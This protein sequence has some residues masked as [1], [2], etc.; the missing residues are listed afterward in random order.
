FVCKLLD[1]SGYNDFEAGDDDEYLVELPKSVK[2]DE[3][4]IALRK[5][6]MF[7]FLPSLTDDWHCANIQVTPQYAGYDLCEPVDLGGIHLKGICGAVFMRFSDALAVKG[8]KNPQSLPVTNLK[9]RVKVKD[10]MWSGSDSDIYIVAYKDNTQWA[11]VCLDKAWNNDL[12]RNETEI[13]DIPI[14][15]YNG[16]VMHIPLDQLNLKIKHEGIDGAKW[17]S[18]VVVPYFG[19]LPLI[20]GAI[21]KRDMNFEDCTL[22][23]NAQS[24]LKNATYPEYEPIEIEYETSLDDGLLSYMG[25]LDGGEEWVDKDNELWQNT[26]L[27]RDIFFKLFKGF[28]PEITYVRYNLAPENNT[29]DLG[30]DFT[31]VWNGVSNERRS[32]VKDLEHVYPVEGSADVEVINENGD[33]VHTL[34]G[35]SVQDGSVQFTLKTDGWESGYYDLKVSYSPNHANPLY[36]GTEMTYEKAVLVGV[37]QA[38]ITPK[39]VTADLGQKTTLTVNASGGKA[40][41]TYT[42]MVP[43]PRGGYAPIQ[44]SSAYAGQGTDTLTCTLDTLGGHSVICE[45]KDAVGSSVW[46][47]TAT[48][49]VK[50]PNT[51][52]G[53][54]LVITT[55]PQSTTID[56]GQKATLTVAASGGKA[57]YTYSW[58]TISSLGSWY[59]VQ[60]NRNYAGQGTN[61]FT[62]THDKPGTAKIR[63]IV[64][65]AN[66]DMVTSD[67][68]TITVQETTAPL[69]IKTQ[70]ANTT[71]EV[72]GNSGVY[73]EAVGGKAPYTYTWQTQIGRSWSTFR[74]TPEFFGQG[75]YALVCASTVAGTATVRCVV[76]DSSGQEVTSKSATITVKAAA[77]LAVRVVQSNNVTAEAGETVRFTVEVSG[78]KAP[79]KFS[80]QEAY[81]QTWRVFR[82]S[83]LYEGQGTDTLN[84]T[85]NSVGTR[86]FRCVVTDSAGNSVT[87]ETISVTV[88]PL[89]VQINGGAKNITFYHTETETLTANVTGGVGPYTYAW[90]RKDYNWSTKAYEWEKVSASSSYKADGS[91]REDYPVKV[92]VTDS[93]GTTVTAEIQVR[94]TGIVN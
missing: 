40:P 65:D 90:Y 27:R 19:D 26:A 76:K 51:G 93:T 14:S 68:A 80:W 77:P 4:E 88:K 25:S 43:Q 28:A 75:T 12:E 41:Y 18:I 36:S 57:P 8:N 22:D 78:G 69:T 33:V 61:T 34:G 84:V 49:T 59:S 20:E 30:F 58:Q 70:P 54:E 37:L 62:F 79:Y 47:E 73:V 64:V 87:T 44:D 35:M 52:T 94:L 5:T 46:S 10:E 38:D 2:L 74:D 55:Q 71:F 42:W 50:Q 31:G 85:P 45:V 24:F 92:E 21:E 56:A 17:E 72:G 83:S 9:V 29:F 60:N 82:D 39:D 48:I 81:G 11:K 7:D 32:Q 15:K 53:P 16:G 1:K 86:K 63:C 67:A 13:Y 91:P 66:G 89:S 23:L 3:L 6:P